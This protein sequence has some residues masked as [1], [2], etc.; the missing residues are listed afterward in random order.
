MSVGYSI[1]VAVSAP[2]S[3]STTGSANDLVI[4]IAWPRTTIAIERVAFIVC[5]DE[6]PRRVFRGNGSRRERFCRQPGFHDRN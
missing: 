3:A 6:N 2:A 1:V 5:A 4:A